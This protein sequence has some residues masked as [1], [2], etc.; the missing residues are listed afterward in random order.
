LAKKSNFDKLLKRIDQ[1]KAES[2]SFRD[3]SKQDARRLKE[4][5]EK[6]NPISLSDKDAKS[7]LKEIEVLEKKVNLNNQ[8]VKNLE[9]NPEMEIFKSDD[10]VKNLSSEIIAESIKKSKLQKRK[11][12]KLI[13]ELAG[14]KKDLL[15]KIAEIGQVVKENKNISKN[16]NYASKFVE[17]EQG[18]RSLKINEQIGASQGIIY[19][20]KQE[21]DVAYEKGYD[22]AS[23]WQKRHYS[24]GYFLELPE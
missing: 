22:L 3:T 11:H 19:T 9:N 5:Q 10:T 4:L 1:L 17:Q 13:K 20:N 14:I 7:L 12:K 2:R 23:Q 24:K 16:F 6:Y 18:H 21:C 15:K 8:A